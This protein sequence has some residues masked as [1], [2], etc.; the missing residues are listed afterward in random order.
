M[1]NPGPQAGEARIVAYDLEID[2]DTSCTEH[3][4]AI[5]SAQNA[6]DRTVEFYALAR[7]FDPS[8]PASINVN[9][10]GK[11]E[12]SIIGFEGGK[13]CGLQA[14]CTIEPIPD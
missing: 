13:S 4:D 6:A 14:F 5:E 8:L 1:L 7:M 10:T 11:C 9:V 12:G 2:R 3:C